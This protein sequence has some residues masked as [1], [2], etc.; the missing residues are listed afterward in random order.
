MTEERATTT[1]EG[2]KN[3]DERVKND[4]RMTDDYRRTSDDNRRKTEDDRRIGEW[5]G[6]D[7][8]LEQRGRTL[9]RENGYASFI[10]LWGV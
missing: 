6:N 9:H 10:V 1:E 7:A 5:I 8:R 3:S 2:A 4:R